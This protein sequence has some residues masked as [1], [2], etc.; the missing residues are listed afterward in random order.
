MFFLFVW[1]DRN[2]KLFN[3]IVGILNIY[4]KMFQG[5]SLFQGLYVLA[6]V[7]IYFLIFKVNMGICFL[8]YTN[9]LLNFFFVLVFYKIRDKIDKRENGKD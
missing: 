5:W 2:G 6:F 8:G 7:L 3:F 9:K 4:E 1:I